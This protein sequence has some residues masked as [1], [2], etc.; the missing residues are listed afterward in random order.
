M[1]EEHAFEHTI[2]PAIYNHMYDTL[3]FWSDFI[4]GERFLGDTVDKTL[5]GTVSSYNAVMKAW[6]RKMS[7]EY[8]DGKIKTKRQWFNKE[9]KDFAMKFREFS[10]LIDPNAKAG[11]QKYD[12]DIQTKYFERLKM[13]F[14]TGDEELFVRTYMSAFWSVYT[15]ES[16]KG[17][18]YLGQGTYT[19]KQALK[20][21]YSRMKKYTRYLNPNKGSFFKEVFGFKSTA[22]TRQMYNQ[23][24]QHLHP[25]KTFKDYKIV[26]GKI[27]PFIGPNT[28]KNQAR[29]IKAETEY[30]FRHRKLFDKNGILQAN[31]IVKHLG[32]DAKID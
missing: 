20:R 14:N 24:M 25:D 12:R 1:N 9:Q 16:Q 6:E 10:R 31:L 5:R 19:D 15:E 8:T 32:K 13:A 7:L 21:A 2:S 27:I 17:K 4:K 30:W 29:I 18:D 28:S 22:E 11:A 3:G 23:W 26:N